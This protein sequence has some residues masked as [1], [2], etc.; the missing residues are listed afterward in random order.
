[1][2]DKLKVLIK[3]KESITDYTFNQLFRMYVYEC[4][5]MRLSKSKYNKNFILKGGYLLSHI[6]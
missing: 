3:D 5:L 4:F 1:M 6:F 2:T